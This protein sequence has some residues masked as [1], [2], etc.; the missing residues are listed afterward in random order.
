MPSKKSIELQDF[1]KEDLLNELAETESQ[2]QKMKFD[3]ATKGLENPLVLR[4]VRRDLA[5]L[6]TEARRREVIEMSA[7]EVGQR[8]RIRA[9]RRSKR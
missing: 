1:S 3:H 7:E 6:K 9:R 4:E 2:F 5:R 8:S